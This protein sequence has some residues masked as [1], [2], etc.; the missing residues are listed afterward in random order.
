MEL[1]LISLFCCAPL[2]L[3]PRLPAAS[4][5]LLKLLKNRLCPRFASWLG[6]RVLRWL[7]W[8]APPH[9]SWGRR[10]RV[11]LR[12]GGL[13]ELAT[14][15]SHPGQPLA[16]RWPLRGPGKA[17]E[18]LVTF[19]RAARPSHPERGRARHDLGGL[20]TP[21]TRDDV[22]GPTTPAHRRT[23]TPRA[24]SGRTRRSPGAPHTTHRFTSTP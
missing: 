20:T 13:P 16:A 12:R 23:S 10:W 18:A 3:L 19:E 17:S 4:W 24:T 21:Q 1:A 2:V 11:P 7:S 15:W 8:R 22:A 14:R 5:L 9:F 6:G